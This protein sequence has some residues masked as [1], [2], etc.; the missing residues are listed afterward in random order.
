MEIENIK[1]LEEFY[2]M[3]IKKMNKRKKTKPANSNVKSAL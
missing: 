1:L 2:K 3:I